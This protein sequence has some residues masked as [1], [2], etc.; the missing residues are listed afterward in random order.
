MAKCAMRRKA[1]PRYE[2]EEEGRKQMLDVQAVVKL[3]KFNR[4][5]VR[6]RVRRVREV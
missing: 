2:G 1:L 3:G 4:S 5:W 6:V